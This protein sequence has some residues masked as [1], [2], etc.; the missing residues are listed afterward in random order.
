MTVAFW[1][2]KDGG[3]GWLFSYQHLFLLLRL[4]EKEMVANDSTGPR[5]DQADFYQLPITKQFTKYFAKTFSLHLQWALYIVSYIESIQ[6]C[7]C[8][9]GSRE[10]P[11]NGFQNQKKHLQAMKSHIIT[12]SAFQTHRAITKG[13]G[14][15]TS[16]QW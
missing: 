8:S 16:N 2:T 13:P 11:K 15:V 5:L 12:Y 3:L 4:Q 7:V 14:V 6:I 9:S 1:C 10:D